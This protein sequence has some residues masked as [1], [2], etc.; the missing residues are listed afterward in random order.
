MTWWSVDLARGLHQA[1]GRPG[2]EAI[3]VLLR[4]ALAPGERGGLFSVTGSDVRLVAAVPEAAAFERASVR[5]LVRDAAASPGPESNASGLAVPVALGD[6]TRG[7]LVILGRG[8]EGMSDETRTRAPLLAPILTLVGEL[9]LAHARAGEAEEQLA[10]AHEMLGLAKPGGDLP[11]ISQ[12]ILDLGSRLV[13]GDSGGLWLRTHRGADLELRAARRPPSRHAPRPR[14]AADE[15]EPLMGAAPLACPPYPLT[16]PRA[17]LRDDSVTAAVLIPIHHDDELVGL[18]TL[19]R[20]DPA[21]PFGPADA[22]RLLELAELAAVPVVNVC[23]REEVRERTRQARAS[24]RIA[25]GISAS[26]SL[27]EIFRVATRELRGITSFDASALVVLDQSGDAGHILVGEAGK[28]PRRT[29]WTP[30]FRDTTTGIVIHSRRAA[31]TPDLAA[32]SRPLLPA[33]RDLPG[34]RSM[35]SVPLGTDDD[36][37]GALV[38][39]SRTRG[40]FRRHDLRLLRPIARQLGLAVRQARLLR[41]ATSG[42]DERLRLELR[43]ARAER[44]ATIGRLAGALAHEIRNPL[45]VIGT[46][47]QYLRDRLPPDHEQR[48]LLDAADRKVREMDES[49]EGLLS[50]SRPLPLRPQPVDVAALLADVAGF[51]RGRA[52]R[53]D[54]EVT[55]ET[56][57]GLSPVALDRR[58]MEQALLNLA[59][60][61]LEAMPTGG[62]LAFAARTAPESGSVLLTVAD[63]GAGIEGPELG[64]IFEPYFTTKRGGTGLGLA[65]TRRIVEEH[66]GAIEATSEP[67]R[68]TT[69]VLALPVD[70]RGP[71][72]THEH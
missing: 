12:A 11:E 38:L 42:F 28:P 49:L 47:V 36:V 58:L 6:E 56:E 1:L 22:A 24:R 61:A 68:G 44:Q 33:L 70:A 59:L 63:T 31:I 46:T 13:D 67:G 64:A 37:I 15:V 20:V 45:T 9:A 52:G 62:R 55:V 41:A 21:R 60:N 7:V 19:G 8:T 30:E 39:V 23:L 71:E 54:V 65:L 14:L 34:A 72:P 18:L 29:V 48:P 5:Q 43:L 57:S 17:L 40:R 10:R 32:A 4:L 51:V 2:A 27:E 66:G 50:F 69:F 53:Q 25:K 26:L 16:L 35:I 3:A